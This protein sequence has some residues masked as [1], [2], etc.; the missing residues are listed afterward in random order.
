MSM[1]Y[2]RRGDVSIDRLDENDALRG[3]S[4]AGG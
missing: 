2:D 1:C 3:P 4:L